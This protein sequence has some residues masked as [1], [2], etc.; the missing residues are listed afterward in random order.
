MFP[1][2]L[3]NLTRSTNRQGTFGP[4]IE[5]REPPFSEEN[6][7]E[8][9]DVEL[10][11]F[12]FKSFTLPACY[13]CNY[14]F[15]EVIER[16]VKPIMSNIM[17]EKKLSAKDFNLLL[18]WFDKIRVGSA[19]ASLYHTQNILNKAPHYYINNGGMRNDRILL[20]YKTKQHFDC[21]NIFGAGLSFLMHYPICIGMIVNNF[22]FINMSYTFMLHKALGL[23]FPAVNPEY[24]SPENSQDVE[25][26]FLKGSNLFSYPL[27]NH[28]YN[29]NCTEIFQPIIPP[30]VRRNNQTANFFYG[31][32]QYNK[33]F[34]STSSLIGNI[35]Y[36]KDKAITRYPAEKSGSWIPSELDCD[37]GAFQ[38]FIA[39]QTLLMQNSF[40]KNGIKQRGKI[41]DSVFHRLNACLEEN[42]MNL[43]RIPL[44]ETFRREK[45]FPV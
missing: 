33:I 44:Y 24:A 45:I 13:N 37:E 8:Q 21:L 2:W 1:S 17:Q 12:H 10:R 7:E 16:K 28:N 31:W 42:N 35:L 39:M 26:L 25:L 5:V 34:P 11:E 3:L 9:V 23:P 4:F 14:E 32:S 18:Q 30:N 19:L 41:P 38:N 27:I 22:G 20:I 36:T 29:T 40:L 15:G 43:R 6:I